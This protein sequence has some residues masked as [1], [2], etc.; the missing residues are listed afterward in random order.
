VTLSPDPCRS[1]QWRQVKW[2]GGGV[3]G[4]VLVLAVLLALEFMKRRL[5]A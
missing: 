3:A 5:V 2:F 4:L 1:Q